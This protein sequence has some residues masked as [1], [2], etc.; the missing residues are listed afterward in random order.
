[1]AGPVVAAAVILPKFCKIKGLND[2]KKIPKS[3]HEAIYK[4]VMKEA[5]AVGAVSYT[6]LEKNRISSILTGT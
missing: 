5:V 3:K 6:H 1:M 2:S 4:Q